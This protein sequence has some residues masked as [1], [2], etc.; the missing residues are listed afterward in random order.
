MCIQ[1]TN[2][3]ELKNSDINACNSQ[4]APL[5]NPL[6]DYCA[7]MWSIYRTFKPKKVGP[8]EHPKKKKKAART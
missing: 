2:R 5:H 7:D 8:V 3:S 6:T 4:L 1:F